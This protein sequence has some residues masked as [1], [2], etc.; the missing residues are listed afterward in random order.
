MALDAMDSQQGLLTELWTEVG[1]LPVFAW[2][3]ANAAPDAPAVVLVHGRG[4][5]S[6]CLLPIARELAPYTAI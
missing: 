2:T 6:T 1:G 4:L 3:S 5:S